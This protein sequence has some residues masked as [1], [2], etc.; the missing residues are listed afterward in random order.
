MLA[1]EIGGPQLEVLFLDAEVE[2][3]DVERGGGG[4]DAEDVAVARVGEEELV[5]GVEDVDGLVV[6]ALAGAQQGDAGI[7]AVGGGRLG[8][9]AGPPEGRLGYEGIGI[10]A[11][12]QLSGQ[13]QQQRKGGVGPG[14]GCVHERCRGRGRGQGG[15]M[16]G[17]AEARWAAGRVRVGGSIHHGRVRQGAAV[18][19]RARSRWS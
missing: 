6:D 7:A 19:R 15:A 14:A 3:G 11:V 16:R 18:G 2:A 1:A 5:V 10:D 17:V 9:G 13:R 8:R 4:D 12:A